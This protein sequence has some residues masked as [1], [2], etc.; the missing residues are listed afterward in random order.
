MDLG[1][2]DCCLLFVVLARGF[3][4]RSWIGGIGSPFDIPGWIG[5]R[6]RGVHG[7]LALRF[8]IAVGELAQWHVASGDRLIGAVVPTWQYVRIWVLPNKLVSY[9]HRLHMYVS[10]T[11]HRISTHFPLILVSTFLVYL[12]ISCRFAIDTCNLQISCATHSLEN[13]IQYCGSTCRL[14]AAV[15]WTSGSTNHISKVR[16]FSLIRSRMVL[17]K[18]TIDNADI[19]ITVRSSPA[20]QV[21][22]CTCHLLLSAHTLLR[23]ESTWHHAARGLPLSLDELGHI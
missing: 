18:A 10:G 17:Q 2:L 22:D 6:E 5:S 4:R 1:R 12:R 15:C 19:A 23:H 7:E 14:H 16:F 8:R 11:Q 13:A 20:G 21:E 9:V 3:A